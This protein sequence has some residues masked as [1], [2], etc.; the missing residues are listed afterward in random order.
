LIFE[1]FEHQPNRLTDHLR[2]AGFTL[3]ALLPRWFGPSLIS[4]DE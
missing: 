3:F 1:D 4:L 2:D